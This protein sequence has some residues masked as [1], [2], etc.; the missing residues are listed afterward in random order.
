MIAIMKT[1]EDYKYA[2]KKG[3]RGCG[4]ERIER[5]SSYQSIA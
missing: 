2:I 1:D 4:C 5:N 3:G